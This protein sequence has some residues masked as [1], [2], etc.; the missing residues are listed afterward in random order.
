[1]SEVRVGHLLWP[2]AILGFGLEALKKSSIRT[3]YTIVFYCAVIRLSLYFH[4]L[5]YVSSKVFVV[6]YE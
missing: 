5:Q 2:S 1:M 4:G 6:A 3:P